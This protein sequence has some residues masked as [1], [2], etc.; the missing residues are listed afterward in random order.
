MVEIFKLNTLALFA[1]EVLR[2][3]KWDLLRLKELLREQ[4]LVWLQ[5]LFIKEVLVFFCLNTEQ[6]YELFIIN[7]R[8]IE[9]EL[10]AI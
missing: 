1:K 6:V 9:F 3:E 4:L 5:A 10:I 2:G 7:L 8:V